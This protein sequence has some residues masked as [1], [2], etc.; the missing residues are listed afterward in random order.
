MSAGGNTL[1][2]FQKVKVLS[3]RAEQLKNNEFPVTPIPPGVHDHTRMA[4]I[5][6]EAGKLVHPTSGA[7]SGSIF[8]RDDGHSQDAVRDSAD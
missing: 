4:E 1:T 3:L 2:K 8:V 7:K 5:E 6:L